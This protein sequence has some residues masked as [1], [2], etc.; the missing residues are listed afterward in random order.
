MGYYR[1]GFEIVGVD[2]KPMPHYPFEFHQADALEYLADHWQE[3][4]AIHASCPCQENCPLRFRWGRTYPGYIEA[5]RDLILQTGKPYIIENVEGA[6]RKLINPLL[7]CGTMFGLRV[8]RHRMFE[9]NIGLIFSPA[10]CRCKGLVGKQGHMG[11]REYMTVTGHFSD[12]EKAGKAMGIDWMTQAE[13]AQ[14]I[15][16]VY[17][18]FIGK[19]LIYFLQS[20]RLPIDF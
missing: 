17:T 11:K 7:L 14:A 2:N 4:D 18:E 16:P 6:K 12:V 13:L 5:T 15:P 20:E 8:I 9:N 19:Q 1:A 10:T 3:F